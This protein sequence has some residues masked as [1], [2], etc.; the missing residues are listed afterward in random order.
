MMPA[1]V[2]TFDFESDYKS[3]AAFAESLR[4]MMTRQAHERVIKE[5]IL[6]ARMSAQIGLCNVCVAVEFTK[7]GFPQAVAE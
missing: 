4:E 6:D 5:P 3:V 7:N 1:I 2:S